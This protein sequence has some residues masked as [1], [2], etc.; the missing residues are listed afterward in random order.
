MIMD[1]TM[2]IEMTARQHRKSVFGFCVP[3]M[4]AL[5][6]TMLMSKRVYVK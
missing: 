3:Y 2:S 1:G 4:A 6:L 5:S